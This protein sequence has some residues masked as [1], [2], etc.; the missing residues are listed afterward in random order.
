MC[1]ALDNA[2]NS[3]HS[4]ADRS[5]SIVHVETRH[6]GNKINFASTYFSSNGLSACRMFAG[7]KNC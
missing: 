6:P 1:R 3:D 2:R 5:V 4:L 7:Y